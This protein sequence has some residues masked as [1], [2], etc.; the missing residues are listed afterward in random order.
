[1]PQFT[2]TAIQSDGQRVTGNIEAF[3]LQAAR[4]ALRQ[5]HL[6]PEELH[7]ETAAGSPPAAPPPERPVEELLSPM[8]AVSP[9]QETAAPTAQARA[10]EERT[11]FPLLDTLRLYAGWLLAWY[12]IVY[13]LGSYQHSRPLPFRVPY[14]EGLFLS[15]L[16]LSFTFAAYLFLLFSGL[17]Q[18]L[19]KKWMSGVLLLAIGIA[20]FVV[21]RMNVV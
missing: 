17:W 18:L 8:P 9:A 12:C 6:I 10:A 2:Y 16:V 7:E 19:G 3:S 4:E 20:V 13:A 21:Y 15:P 1:M 5:M 11:Y 14:V